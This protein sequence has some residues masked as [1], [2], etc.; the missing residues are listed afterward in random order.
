MDEQLA[1][2][3]KLEKFIFTPSDKKRAGELKKEIDDTVVRIA[4]GYIA[5]HQGFVRLGALVL[6]VEQKKFWYLW[7][8]TSYH[9]Y[10][11]DLGKKI[12]KGHTQIYN[13]VSVARHLLPHVNEKDLED[14]GITNANALARVVRITGQAPSEGIVEAGKAMTL[15]EYR[16]ALEKEFKVIDT[17]PGEKYR[18]LGGFW[19]TDEEW[20]TIQQALRIL[21]V[22]MIKSGE[23]TKDS[24]EQYIFKISILHM[25]EE[26]IG[27]YSEEESNDR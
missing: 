14:M 22:Q 24:N 15:P 8:S 3:E 1:K 16:A 25:A 4:D 26:I 11:Y 10:I 19:C 2:T 27:T 13:A 12:L 20:E 18:D 6:E 9:N 17:K 23:V 5:V 7:G 21:K